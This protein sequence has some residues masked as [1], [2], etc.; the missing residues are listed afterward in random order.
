MIIVTI[1]LT[2]QQDVI[3]ETNGQPESVIIEH[4]ESYCMHINDDEDEVEF[5]AL[6]TNIEMC[7]SPQQN[8]ESR[9][10][11]HIRTVIEYER[12]TTDFEYEFYNNMQTNTMIHAFYT[13]KTVK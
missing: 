12:H 9:E 11:S 4:T 3:N 7:T 8:E 6:K 10:Y 2:F 1:F 5:G 13:R